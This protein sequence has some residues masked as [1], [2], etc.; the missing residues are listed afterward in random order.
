MC[1]QA[2]KIHQYEITKTCFNIQLRIPTK[3]SW[4]FEENGTVHYLDQSEYTFK[5]LQICSALLQSITNE[6]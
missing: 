2:T 4:N 3:M 6:L 5:P 1:V